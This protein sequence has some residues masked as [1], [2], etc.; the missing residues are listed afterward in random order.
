MRRCEALARCIAD[1][2]YITLIFLALMAVAI[3]GWRE[4]AAGCCALE[5]P[6]LEAGH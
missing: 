3:A 2:R 1:F 5:P 4:A 6:M